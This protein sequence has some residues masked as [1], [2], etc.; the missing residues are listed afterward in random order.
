MKA[1]LGNLVALIVLTIGCFAVMATI[2]LGVGWPSFLISE[3]QAKRTTEIPK[4]PV[5]VMSAEP[6]EVEV[7]AT[8]TGMLRPFER[9]VLGFEVSGRLESLGTR[10]DGKTLDQGDRVTA[11][12]V[13]AKLDDKLATAQLKE[14]RARLEQAQ[15]DMNRAQDLRARG[16]RVITDAE[17]QNFVTQLQL[18]EAAVAMA[19]KRLADATLIAPATGKISKR[20]ANA[21]ES[22]NMH[23]TIFEIVEVD[24]VLL[25]VG[26]PESQIGELAVGQPAQ[27][28]LL[29]TDRFGQKKTCGQGTVYRVGETADDKTGLFEVE[30]LIDNE[31][32]ELRP[33]LVAT[34]HIVVAK[35]NAFLLPMAS[36]VHRDGK[37][38][39]YSVG[40]DGLAHVHELT[41]WIEQGQE[42]LV[43]EIPPEHRQ[44]VVRGQHRLVEGRAVEIIP[45]ESAGG[46]S[47]E[48]NLTQAANTQPDA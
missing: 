1:G 15:T 18:A 10:E 43:P 16:Q 6:E 14:A 30:L 11:G 41:R 36:A 7:T 3:K 8:Y 27:L 31:K 12:Q 48:T 47:P 34:A 4:S 46:E 25:A 13:L 2:S 21:G 19:E 44:I 9:Y 20:L 26:V 28:D 38:L 33:G 42:I 37:V 5:A 32:Q 22:I 29:G 24:R 23:Q 35:L 40:N 39:I 17:F 45:S